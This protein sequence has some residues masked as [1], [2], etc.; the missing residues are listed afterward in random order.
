MKKRIEGM[1]LELPGRGQTRVRLEGEGSAE[2]MVSI[3]KFPWFPSVGEWFSATRSADG[4]I[5][6][7]RQ[8]P[9]ANESALMTIRSR[10][11]QRHR[12]VGRG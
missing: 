5:D 9:P 6:D 12:K 7:L 3:A 1:I 2:L 4:G 11:R 10:R 8:S